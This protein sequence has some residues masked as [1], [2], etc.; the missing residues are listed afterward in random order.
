LH[1]ITTHSGQI[2]F[3]SSPIRFSTGTIYA[4]TVMALLLEGCMGKALT[5][6]GSL[7]A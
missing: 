4:V 5:L 2:S 3:K 1:S 6:Q 7:A